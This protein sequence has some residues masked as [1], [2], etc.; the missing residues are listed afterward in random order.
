MALTLSVLAVHTFALVGAQDSVLKA[1]AV[2]LLAAAVFTL[3]AFEVLGL[4]IADS[5][6]EGGNVPLEDF[7]DGCSALVGEVN[8]V[9][10]GVG[11]IH[12]AIALACRATHSLVSETLAVELETLGV[13]ALAALT[14]C[15]LLLG[16]FFEKLFLSEGLSNN[17][18]SHNL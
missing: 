10:T 6:V 3:A 8:V 7:S 4:L 5:I 18:L 2:L 1:L 9:V 13:L 11:L 12:V 16:Q 15:F 14:C 17:L